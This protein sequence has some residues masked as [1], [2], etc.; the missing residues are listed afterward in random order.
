[1]KQ[2]LRR[3]ELLGSVQVASSGWG[4]DLQACMKSSLLAPPGAYTGVYVD[5]VPLWCIANQRRC[6]MMLDMRKGTCGHGRARDSA[7]LSSV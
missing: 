3:L 7:G 2:R 1:M 4:N 6:R 5:N